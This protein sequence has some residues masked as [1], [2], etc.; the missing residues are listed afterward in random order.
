M[1]FDIDTIQFGKDA[2]IVSFMEMPSD[3][4]VEGKVVRQQRV[5]LSYRHP[6][7]AEDAEALELLAQRML[8]NAM[9]DFNESPPFTPEPGDDDD[10]DDEGMG[11]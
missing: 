5:S 3:V 11:Q 2:V 9:E 10:D 7:Y 1:S 8:R 6:D 4:R